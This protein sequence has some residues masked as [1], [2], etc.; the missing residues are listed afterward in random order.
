M[1][2]LSGKHKSILNNDTYNYKEQTIKYFNNA[3]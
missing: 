1:T 3:E 2:N